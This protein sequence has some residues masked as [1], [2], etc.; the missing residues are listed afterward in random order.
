LPA[1]FPSIL[2]LEHSKALF[3]FHSTYPRNE[4]LVE[5]KKDVNSIEIFRKFSLL[6]TLSPS[7][8]QFAIFIRKW[9]N[10]RTNVV[11]IYMFTTSVIP[12]AWTTWANYRQCN[13]PN[14]L[15]PCLTTYSLLKTLKLRTWKFNFKNG[16]SFSFSNVFF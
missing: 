7:Y 9:V 12:N 5:F 2:A 6:S 15:P 3:F 4:L 1:N 8:M 11:A 13:T 14:R 10:V 16:Q